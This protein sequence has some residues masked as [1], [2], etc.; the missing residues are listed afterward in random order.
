MNFS[1]MGDQV[2]GHFYKR[3]S[4]LKQVSRNL[5]PYGDEYVVTAIY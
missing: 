2:I 1:F 4:G 3:M 5:S